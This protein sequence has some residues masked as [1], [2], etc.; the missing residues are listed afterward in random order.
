M[1]TDLPA[2]TRDLRE[3]KLAGIAATIDIRLQ[4]AVTRELSHS[5]FLSLLIEDEKNNRATN[6]IKR[7]QRQ[8]HLPCGITL[9]N[10][11]FNFQPKLNKKLIFELATANFIEQKENVILMGQPGTGK[12]HLAT[13]I[14]QKALIKGHRVL[15]VTAS[16][17]IEALQHSHAEGTYTRRLKSYL[18][19][20]LLVID[21]L[22]FKSLPSNVVNDFF[23]IIT[24]RHEQ[25]SI[26]I[27]SNHA[28]EEWGNIFDNKVLATAI[29]DRIAH[30]SHPILIEGESYRIKEHLS[31]NKKTFPEKSAKK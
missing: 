5:E 31:K 23:D 28:F 7:R 20:D 25:K 6:G 26:I 21:E 10:Y 14:A 24:K 29:I 9:E 2:L 27:T 11:D 13:A 17:M 8:A 12:T 4:E 18:A 30:H 1:A 3:L 19:P 16:D 15:F 22:G